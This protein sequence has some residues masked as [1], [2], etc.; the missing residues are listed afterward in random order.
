MIGLVTASP[1]QQA[2]ADDPTPVDSVEIKY[3]SPREIEFPD[4]V[5]VTF[6]VT[7]DDNAATILEDKD[8]TT[9]ILSG[10]VNFE[11]D[12]D[13]L[14][15]RAKQILD[16]LGAEWTKTPPSKVTIVGHTDS[17]ADDAYN[18]DL[19][20]RRAKVVGDYL[21]SKAPGLSVTADGKGETQ[22]I[23]DNTTEEGKA[24]NRRVEIRA[25]K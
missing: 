7:T 16:Q 5:Q 14:T 24:Q 6:T 2:F 19:S 21:S 1:A 18:L 25:E 11:V 10:D 4:P 20:K 15:A 9:T 23:G 22:P 3:P 8:T 17:V 13:Q 12:S